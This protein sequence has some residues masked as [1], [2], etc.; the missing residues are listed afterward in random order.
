MSWID[1]LAETVNGGIFCRKTRIY[2]KYHVNMGGGGRE[3]N[4]VK[5]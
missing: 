1:V 5:P 4:D 3:D 2:N